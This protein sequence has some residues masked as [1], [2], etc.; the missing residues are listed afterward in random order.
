V[1]DPAAVDPAGDDPEARALKE[2]MAAVNPVY[3]WLGIVILRAGTQ[4][5]RFAM[6]VKPQHANTF[7]VCHGG[8]V[9]AFADLA[10]G[11]TCNARGERAATADAS[12]DFL[13]PVPLGD[14]LI[15][16]VTLTAL[17]GRNAYYGVH[18][19]LASAPGVPVG[20]VRGRMRITGGPLLPSS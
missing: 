9:F 1:S 6:D 5:A 3:Q 18:L 2:A 16:D 19:S 8:I 14:R 7:G 15:A 13:K 11:F 10:L 20:L 17:S 12:I 4:S